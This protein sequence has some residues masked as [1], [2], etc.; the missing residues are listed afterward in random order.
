M[1]RQVLPVIGAAIGAYFGGSTGAQIGW[2]IG[3]A[4]GNAVDPLVVKGPQIGDLAQQTSQEGVPRPIVFGLS[5]PMSGNIVACAQPVIKKKRT[6]QGK[7][8]G[9]VTE[10]QQ[11]FRTYAIGV[12]EGPIQQF[13]RVWRNGSLVYDARPGHTNVSMNVKFLQT[14]R[15]FLGSF[16]QAAS[17]DLQ[18]KFG[19]AATPFMRGTA[20]MVMANEDLTN[21]QGAV[22]Q[23]AFQVLRCEGRLLTSRP[24]SLFALEDSTI[25]GAVTFGGTVPAPIQIDNISMAGS[26][27]SGSMIVTTTYGSYDAGHDDTSIVGSLTSGVLTVTTTYGSYD[28]GHDDITM[29]A[30]LSSGALTVTTGYVSYLIPVEGIS[31]KGSLV[32]GVLA[33]V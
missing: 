6:S 14:A 28:A 26:L 5:Q 16:S 27:T 30:R 25:K 31:M 15:F 22:P 8:G 21:L 19:P 7:G 11:V 12:C 2:A 29:T 17:A 1:A 4:V 13:I 20:Y 32:A 3:S 18:A 33:N 23:Y 24:Y 10:T 9:P